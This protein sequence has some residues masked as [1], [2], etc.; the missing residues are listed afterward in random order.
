MDWRP[1]MRDRTFPFGFRQRFSSRIAPEGSSLRSGET[2]EGNPTA[3]MPHERDD[4]LLEPSLASP[5][6]LLAGQLAAGTSSPEDIPRGM[7]EFVIPQQLSEFA[8]PQKEED[9]FALVDPWL[10]AALAL[11]Y[12]LSGP[13]LVLSNNCDHLGRDDLQISAAG[14]ALGGVLLVAA[15][16]G[17]LRA[18]IWSGVNPWLVHLALRPFAL[19]IALALASQQHRLYRERERTD[20]GGV[21]RIA[22]AEIHAAAIM[23]GLLELLLGGMFA[24]LFHP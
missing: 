11:P 19:A 10:V 14:I 23:T 15:V 1:L 13:G 24:W 18:G 12:G 6:H 3:A 7:S 20:P 22:P 17:W 16:Y 21:K 5:D 9:G 2:Q 8:I 4:D